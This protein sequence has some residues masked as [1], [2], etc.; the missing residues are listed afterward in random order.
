MDTVQPWPLRWSRDN[1]YRLCEAE[2]FLERRVQLIGG[3]IF[4]FGPSNDYHA[5]AIALTDDELRKAFGSGYWIRIRGLLDVSDC[6][7]PDPDLAVVAGSPR[8]Y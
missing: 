8:Q 5:A 2:W 6:S 3:E 1:Y 4:E 7:V